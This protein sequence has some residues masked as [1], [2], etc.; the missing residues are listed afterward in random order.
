MLGSL[1][2]PV[3]MS[4]LSHLGK[5][6]CQHCNLSKQA[7]LCMIQSAIQSGKS[8]GRFGISFAT[9]SG[10]LTFP[11]LQQNPVKLVHRLK[12]VAS[13]CGVLR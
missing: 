7:Y 6:Q 8:L 11:K 9:S 1:A 10:S 12:Y 5:G 2:F 13:A 4:S 3:R